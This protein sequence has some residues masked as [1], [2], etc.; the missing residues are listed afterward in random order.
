MESIFVKGTS[1]YP[2]ITLDKSSGR[3]EFFGNSIPE[4]AKEF[5]SPIFDWWD[6]YVQH[7]NANTEV[8]FRMSYYNTP[9]SKMFFHI[10]KKL[11]TLKQSGATVKVKWFYTEDDVDMRDAGY[12][13][14]ENIALPI[15]LIPIPEEE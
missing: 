5:F 9:S 11:E 3:F 2:E 13:F 8:T 1:Q 14:A 12:D 10:L 6:E 7:P 15:E 4:D